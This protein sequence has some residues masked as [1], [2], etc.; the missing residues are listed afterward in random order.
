MKTNRRRLEQGRWLR[1]VPICTAPGR[2]MNQGRSIPLSAEIGRALQ[3]SFG[4][5]KAPL[6]EFMGLGNWKVQVSAT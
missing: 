4:E 5:N 6:S 1:W 2:L 3:D